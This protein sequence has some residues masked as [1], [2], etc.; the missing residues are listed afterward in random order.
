MKSLFY[1]ILLACLVTFSSFTSKK[2][3]N[4]NSTET[5]VI[6]GNVTDS[7]NGESLAGVKIT[8][9]GTNLVT[10]TDFDGNFE[11]KNMNNAE[12]YSLTTAYISYKESKLKDIKIDNRSKLIKIELEHVN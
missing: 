5:L 10:Y 2:P 4:T 11:F 1:V 7:Q 8:I 6:K 3:E 9:D 12:N